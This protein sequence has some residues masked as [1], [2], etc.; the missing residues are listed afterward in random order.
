MTIF[1]L[2]LIVVLFLLCIRRIHF[3]WHEEKDEIKKLLLK[4]WNYIR[5]WRTFISFLL[6]WSITNGWCYVFIVLGTW[7]KIKWMRITGWSYLAFLWLPT[8]PEKLVTIPLS[9]GIK[10]LLFR[11]KK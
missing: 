10:K 11:R 8:T 9:V 1:I 3:T 7:L 2:I 5:D 6:A 4:I